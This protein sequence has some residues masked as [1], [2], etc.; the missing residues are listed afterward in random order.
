MVWIE[1][2]MQVQLTS[3]APG[4]DSELKLILDSL[5]QLPKS[6]SLINPF[7]PNATF[8]YP[9]KTSENRKVSYCFQ[10]IAKGCI[11]SKYVNKGQIAFYS[12]I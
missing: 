1:R 5:H 3:C 7:V 9:L 12:F 11:E 2:H 8:L 6:Y 10:R 4:R